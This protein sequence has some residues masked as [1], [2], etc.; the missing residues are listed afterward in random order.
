MHITE[1]FFS[2]RAFE[3]AYDVLCTILNFRPH[4]GVADPLGDVGTKTQRKATATIIGQ[5]VSG[6]TGHLIFDC[7]IARPK[8][9]FFLHPNETYSDLF[10]YKHVQSVNG[11]TLSLFVTHLSYIREL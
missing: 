2:S 6:M 7:Q 10:I 4:Y 8:K 11:Q 3:L 9:C 1:Q 5:S